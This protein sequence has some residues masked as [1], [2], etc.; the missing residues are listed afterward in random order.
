MP[1]DG[2][3]SACMLCVCFRAACPCT[4]AALRSDLCLMRPLEPSLLSGS[5]APGPGAVRGSV[6][7]RHQFLSSQHLPVD[8]GNQFPLA[9]GSWKWHITVMHAPPGS[10]GTARRCSHSAS[11]SML[12]LLV[13]L[14]GLCLAKC[15]RTR[16]E[17]WEL[18]TEVG[19]ENKEEL[20]K[21]MAAGG[22]DG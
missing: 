10:P 18:G 21:G 19:W 5:C 11:Y 14:P 15:M 6:H 8:T 16:A 20:S 2:Q 1:H 7:Y 13:C 22:G 9:T 12:G 17:R 4:Q 3:E